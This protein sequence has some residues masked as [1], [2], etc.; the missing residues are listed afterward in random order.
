MIKSG[1]KELSNSTS[2]KILET[3]M[4]HLNGLTSGPDCSKARYLVGLFCIEI[5]FTVY[6]CACNFK[7]N[8]TE[9]RKTNNINRKLDREVTKMKV[10]K[11]LPITG[12]V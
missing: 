6:G 7:M 4:S 11:T 1:N 8:E 2:W 12:L 3:V 5:S 9:N 10:T